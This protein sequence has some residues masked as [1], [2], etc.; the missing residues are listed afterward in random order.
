MADRGEIRDA[1]YNE[2]SALAGT[3][4]VTDSAGNTIG[5]VT[6]SED[7]IGLREPEQSE[8][9]PQ[10][11]YHEDYTSVTFNGVGSGP[12][13]V[14]RDDSGDVIEEIWRAYVEAQFIIDVRAANETE[15]EPIYESLRRTF[16]KYTVQPWDKTSL[17]PDVTDITI[18]GVSTIDAGDTEDVIRGDRLEIGVTFHRDYTLDTA[19]IKTINTAFDVDDDDDGTIDEDYTITQ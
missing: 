17:H 19:L 2:L 4:N 12:D 8:S 7:D 3:Y 18:R 1:F 14:T 13:V 11:V 16:E 5:T 9:L 6:L 15:K 10:I